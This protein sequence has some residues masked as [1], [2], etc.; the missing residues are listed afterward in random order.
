MP[1]PI[2][3]RAI[4]GL[5]EGDSFSY[6]REFTKEETGSFGDITRDYNPVHYDTRWTDQKGYKGLICHG[7]LVGSMI[8]EF[9]GQVGWLATGMSFNY[10]KPVYFGDAVNCA[11]TIK[12]IEENGRAEAEAVFTNQD[13]EQVCYAQ[14]SGRLPLTAEQELLKRMIGE[15][16]PFNKLSDE[17]YI[18]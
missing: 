2:R 4:E 13:G 10:I 6:T 8:C 12:K 9:G 16:D 18:L 14:L 11:V 17:K 3:I 5:K 7:L 1:N 15:D